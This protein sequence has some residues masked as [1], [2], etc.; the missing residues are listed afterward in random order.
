MA[1]AKNKAEVAEAATSEFE[2]DGVIYKFT[3]HAFVL[4]GKVITSEEAL[5]DATI[6]AELVNIKAGVIAPVEQ[7][8]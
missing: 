8:D 4:N 5:Q 6:L 7:E 1:K 2:A 3:V